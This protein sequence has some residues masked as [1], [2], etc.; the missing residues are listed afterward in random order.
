MIVSQIISYLR[1][2]ESIA[3]DEG[4]NSWA[5][6]SKFCKL[7]RQESTQSGSEEVDLLQGQVG[8]QGPKANAPIV[9]FP[10]GRPL[11]SYHTVPLAGQVHAL[12]RM[13]AGHT[14]TPVKSHLHSVSAIKV[15]SIR[16]D[17]GQ[18][19]RFWGN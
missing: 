15:S 11:H 18:Y 3:Q 14:S 10:V 12:Q 2:C 17:F 4:S 5:G 9:E 6:S 8:Q 1:V 19:S 13:T 16:V 7:L